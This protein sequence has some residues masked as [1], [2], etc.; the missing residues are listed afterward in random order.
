MGDE[1][2]WPKVLPSPGL[3]SPP[4][5][6]HMGFSHLPNLYMLLEHAL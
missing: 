1:F 4:V 5:S 3:L 6:Q 2:Q